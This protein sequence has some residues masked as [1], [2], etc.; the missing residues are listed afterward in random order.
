MDLLR[1]LRALSVGLGCL[2]FT[3]PASVL[4]AAPPAAATTA[5]EPVAQQAEPISDVELN[6]DGYLEGIVL[7]VD[8]MPVAHTVVVIR[9]IGREA[10][11]AETDALGRFSAGRLR[12]GTYQVNVGTHG[13]LFR[14]WAA[15]TGPPVAGKIALV[16]VGSHVMR[17][18]APCRYYWEETVLVGFVAAMI[19][20]D[21]SLG[22]EG[23]GGQASSCSGVQRPQVPQRILDLRTEHNEY[24]VFQTVAVLPKEAG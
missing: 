6:T 17:A 18:Q 24:R 16:V 13:R 15:D 4:I 11:R 8:A 10:A 21:T 20:V 5:S 1:V 3:L 22:I 2:G 12:G 23:P 9:Q 14:V 19:A 7:D